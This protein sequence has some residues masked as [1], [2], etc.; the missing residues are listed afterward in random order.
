MALM[1]VTIWASPAASRHN[2]VSSFGNY[3]GYSEEVYDSWNRYSVYV[4][5]SDGIQI[6]L[7]Y[8]LPTA[9]GDEASEPLPVI[10]H[11]TRYIRATEVGDIVITQ[12]DGDPVLQ[13]ML[14]HGYAVAVADARGT[15]ASYGVHNGAFSAEETA[16]SYEI[17]EWLANQAW[18][19]GHVGM[20]GRSYPGMTQYHA[21]TQAPAYLDAIFPE[22]AGPIVYDFIYRG[23]TYKSDFINVWG[24]ATSL[25]DQGLA[26]LP[27][28]VDIDTTGSMRD[29]AITQHSDNL[30]ATAFGHLAK[31]RNWSTTLDNGG[32][33]SWD[34]ISTIN[35]IDE[36]DE[37]GIA[38]YHLVGWYDI[39][40]TQQPTLYANLSS[41]PQKMMIG[42]WVHS[43]GYGGEVHR[44]EFLRWYDY[45]LKGVE[46][47][48]M[49]EKPIH[50]YI[51]T[52]NH[53]LPEE[54]G[55]LVSEDE[56][57]AEDG[58]RWQATKRWPPRPNMRKNY[59]FASGPSGTVDSFNDGRLVRRKTKAKQGQ[60]EY[61]VDYTSISS[62]FTRWMNGYGARRPDPV[63]TTFFDERTFEDEK[64]LT[65]T[66]APMKKDLVVVG[67]PVV[68][69]WVSS[70]HTDGDF[71]V[72]L[73]EVDDQGNSHYITE[74]ALRASY[75]A[76]GTAPWDN[77]GLPFHRCQEEDLAE[78]PDEPVELVFDL[79]G[80]SIVIDAGHRIR[81]TVACA[82][83]LN[84]ALYPDPDGEDAPTITLYRN[85][86]YP[87]FIELPVKHG[88]WHSKRL[89]A[90]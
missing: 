26:G 42:P 85:R 29:E 31:Y 10:L 60:D 82:D 69:L 32:Y 21:A 15:G 18:C 4:T 78:L 30:W 37:A 59:Y 64:A 53:T 61:T 58:T 46:N 34:M 45:W 5:M 27:A 23:G 65:Y 71:L 57:N 50:Y 51:M 1:L 72:Y 8:F 19:D 47:G 90:K 73:E 87:S 52:G 16:D 54:T 3:S 43:G 89:K 49:K 48:I 79:M 63:G 7:D 24:Y 25:M 77:F 62:T 76:L 81:V 11:Y 41:T 40:T 84:Y 74:G 12:V 88:R 86:N 33:W 55:E 56:V 6:A 66:S 28:P 39:Y 22:M 44:N 38:V 80:T 13:N 35:S 17:I 20:H 14:A 75:R 67:Y 36:I 83:A 68:H 70:T 9:N 2:W